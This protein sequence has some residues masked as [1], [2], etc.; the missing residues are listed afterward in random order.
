VADVRVA[1]LYDVHG[2]APA[3]EAVLADVGEVDAIVFG[4]DVVFGPW[5]HEAL[6]LARE[7]G[8][9]FVMGNTDRL[10]VTD[11]E[12]ASALWVQERLDPEERA[13]VRS[14]RPTVSLD[15]VL[16]CH[17][18]PRSDE[19]V[20][21][22]TSAESVWEEELRDVGERI[23]VCGHVHLQYDEEHAGRRVVNAGSVGHPTVEAVAWWAIIDG[24]SVELRRS[25]YDTEAT[26]DA[27]RASG[28]PRPE[29]A[30]WLL[31]PLSRDVFLE[32][33]A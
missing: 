8:D 10:A 30:D 3:L 20:V 26:A 33:L 19:R 7:V 23:V 16:Y 12:D 17:A 2:N 11:Q 13:F 31:N 18:T 22:P 21:L 6:A 15:G 1:A 9:H 24:G 27:M 32:L 14:W 25:T 5:P 29:F 28:F 4:G